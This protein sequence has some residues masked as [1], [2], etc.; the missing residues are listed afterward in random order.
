METEKL[1]NG[2][3]VEIY[4]DKIKLDEG[5]IIGTG[6]YGKN[7]IPKVEYK[8]DYL[9]IEGIIEFVVFFEF[10][11]FL[12]GNYNNQE[13]KLLFKHPMH[14]DKKLIY[15]SGPVYTFKKIERS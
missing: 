12:G 2:T 6:T 8:S 14:P 4:E 10:V 11:V 7:A 9:K 3:K 13:W 5:T 15:C 1:E